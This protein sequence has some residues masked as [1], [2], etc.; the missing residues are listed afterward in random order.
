LIIIA[1]LGMFNGSSFASPQLHAKESPS[2]GGFFSSSE[3]MPFSQTEGHREGPVGTS[4]ERERRYYLSPPILS[5]S[6]FGITVTV[7][8]S[9]IA[10][11]TGYD[12]YYKSPDSYIWELLEMGNETT[13]S[14]DLSDGATLSVYITAHR[15]TPYTESSPSNIVSFTLQRHNAKFFVIDGLKF[16]KLSEKPITEDYRPGYLK[17]ALLN[18]MQLGVEDSAVYSYGGGAWES[19]DGN[20][21]NTETIVPDLI[22]KLSE[23][24]SKARSA[25]P[26]EKFIM[27]THSWG[28]VLGFLALGF[29]PDVTPDLFITL[30]SPIGTLKRPKEKD[31]VTQI[32]SSIITVHVLDKYDK[33]LK[34]L[35]KRGKNFVWPNYFGTDRPWINYWVEGDVISGPLKG[36]VPAVKDK[37]VDDEDWNSP[38]TKTPYYHAI[39]SLNEDGQW[40]FILEQDKQF[41]GEFRERVKSDIL[42]AVI[43]TPTTYTNSLGQTFVLLPAGTFTMGSPPDEPRNNDETQHQVTLSKSFYMMTTEV[44]LAQWEEVMGSTPSIPWPSWAGPPCQDPSCPVQH[45]SWDDVQDY[46]AQMNLRGEGTYSLPTEAQWEY[47]ARAG[48][49]TAFANGGITGLYCGISPGSKPDPNLDAMGWYCYNSDDTIHPVA[50]KTP[51]AWGLY[52]MHGNVAEWCQDWWEYSYPSKAV[53]DPTGPSSGSYRVLRGGTW[54]HS[55]FSCR[56]A[57][58][59]DHYEPGGKSPSFGF[60]LVRQP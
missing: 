56:S 51:N 19:W 47:A 5:V 7:S 55:P 2:P 45:V 39:T 60:R 31:V 52:D 50:Q 8:W 3:P 17:P 37:T 25:T 57:Y 11:A 21:M 36:L 15:H 34:E 58:R 43:D 42:A 12:L 54:N 16:S 9:P 28:T 13:L 1:I 30:S 46:I 44:T 23:E 40:W 6:T 22:E 41:A 20:S 27:V 53:T 4:G 48:S 35:S 59:G 33:T 38:I 18:G 29:C 26:P 10:N 14:V 32:A 49:T 24:F